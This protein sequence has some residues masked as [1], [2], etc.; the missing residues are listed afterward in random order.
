[1]L[2][3]VHWPF[4]PRELNMGSWNLYSVDFRTRTIQLNAQTC[5]H[6]AEGRPPTLF[7]SGKKSCTLKLGKRYHVTVLP[8]AYARHILELNFTAA[9]HILQS[10]VYIYIYICIYIYTMMAEHY[11]HAT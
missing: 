11:T 7:S 1:M 6:V 4:R 8:K 2:A 5:F 10:I 9:R 3:E